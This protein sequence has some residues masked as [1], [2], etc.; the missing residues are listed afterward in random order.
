MSLITIM[1]H[2]LINVLLS[3]SV[4]IILCCMLEIL[5]L[6]RINF[7]TLLDHFEVVMDLDVFA[8]DCF[9]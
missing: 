1:V 4:Y 8:Y 7:K 3:K 2:S 9:D 6:V 5:R